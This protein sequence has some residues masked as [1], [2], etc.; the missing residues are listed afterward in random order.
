M[1][2]GNPH[3]IK[4]HCCTQIFSNNLIILVINCD[5]TSNPM[6][7]FDLVTGCFSVFFLV[8][9]FFNQLSDLVQFNAWQH[10]H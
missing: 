8:W 10:H 4:E 2:T 9:V 6:S 3:M 7:R 1:N 5:F